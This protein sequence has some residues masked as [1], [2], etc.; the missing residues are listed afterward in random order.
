MFVVWAKDDTDTIGG[1]ILERGMAGLSTPK[2]DGKFSLR[3]SSTGEIVMDEVFVPAENRL[4]EARGL[5]G[6]FGCLNKARYGISWGA[7]GAAEFCWHAARQYT[8]ERKPRRYER[9]SRADF[10]LRAR[11]NVYYWY[12]GSLACFVA[13]DEVWEDWNEAL[14]RVLPDAQNDDGSFEPLDPYAEIARDHAGD[15]SYATAMC[16]L[17]LEVYYRYFTPLLEKQ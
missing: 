8:L 2:I 1:F 9:P 5:G 6:P 13:G 17:S 7:I 12:Y 15:K 14:K 11:G 10:V 16:V 3:A 4:P